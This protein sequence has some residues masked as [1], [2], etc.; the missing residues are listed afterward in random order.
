V[1]ASPEEVEPYVEI[2]KELESLFF[3]GNVPKEK[4][5]VCSASVVTFKE[6][7]RDVPFPKFASDDCAVTLT[8]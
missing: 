1:I 5:I 8:T 3:C 7:A 4:A 2:S 6:A